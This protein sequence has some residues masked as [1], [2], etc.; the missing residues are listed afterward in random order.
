M[1]DFRIQGV[2][3][4]IVTDVD[5]PEGLGRVRVN[6]PW[7]SE[8]NQSQW[9][10]VATLMA[11]KERGSWFL[12]EVDDEALVAFELGDPNHPYIVGYLWNG[13]DK[14]PN[15]DI[16]TKVRRL[17]TVSGHVLEF[18]DRDGKE[19][20]YLKT[21]GENLVELNDRGGEEGITIKTK[22]GQKIELKDSPTGSINIETKSGQKVTVDDAAQ[23]IT[24]KTTLHS[25]TMDA[26][27]VTVSAASGVLNITC[28]QA[29]VT[30]SSMLSVTAPFASFSGVVQVTTLLAS[31]VVS[32]A[33]TP[34]PGNTFG[35]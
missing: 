14:P 5:D 6:F 29:N 16:D 15:S 28:L 4:G 22:G 1:A 24:L 19:R 34:A 12:P 20:V 11:G 25:V 2:G 21:Q 8:D 35:L 17:K 18:D 26:T 32:S 23:S 27:G 13:K 7:L 31:A 9:A 30:A 10:R 33:Y 3:V